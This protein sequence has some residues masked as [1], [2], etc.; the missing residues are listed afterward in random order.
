MW[1]EEHFGDLPVDGDIIV[2]A[3]FI[4]RSFNYAISSSDYAV[5]NDP[6][7]ESNELELK[8][9]E[10]DVDNKRRPTDRQAHPS[11]AFILCTS[12]Q[13][14]ASKFAYITRNVNPH[15][16]NSSRNRPKS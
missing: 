7:T 2:S 16:T 6:M 5:M 4:Y 13:E 14:L 10:V 12:F 9:N 1:W 8:L 11:F 3:Y 15:L